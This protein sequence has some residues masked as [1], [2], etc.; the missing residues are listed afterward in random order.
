MSCRLILV[1]A[2]PDFVVRGSSRRAG[3]TAPGRF[4]Q[5]SIASY[6]SSQVVYIAPTMP[7]T[8]FGV[9]VPFGD[10]GAVFVAVVVAGKD[11]LQA[12]VGEELAVLA[13]QAAVPVD[14]ADVL[15]QPLPGAFERAVDRV[16][17][18]LRRCASGRT[19]RSRPRSRRRGGL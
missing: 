18:I 16:K 17:M 10:G 3:L 6:L 11:L 15:V 9:G 4:A 5:A 14:D 19:Y 1:I 12:Q 8:P 2:R 13:Q 7:G